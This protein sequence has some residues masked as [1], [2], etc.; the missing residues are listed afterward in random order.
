MHTILVVDDEDRI[1][2]I[3]K[4]LFER[5]GFKVIDASNIVDARKYLKTVQIDL[6]L[7]DINMGEL[8][9]DILYEVARCFHQ[10]IKIIVSSVYPVEDQRKLMPDALDYFDKSEGNR[11][12]VQKVE[13]AL[14]NQ[15]KLKKKKVILIIDDDPKQKELFRNMLTEAGYNSIELSDDKE[16]ICFL[17]KQ[18]NKIDLIVLDLAMPSKTGI[19]YF[20]DIKE[21]YQKTKVLIAS[22]Y[23]IEE[24][25]T[26][27]FDAD[28][29]FDKS[30]GN[31]VFLKKVAQLV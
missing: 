30:D 31:A 13:R 2:S 21:K 9:G 15:E 5:K 11:T 25:K 1:R 24:Q 20:D 27:V 17:K 14:V 6:I 23:S 4:S 7:L 12:L 3:Y 16:V 28:D 22:N 18:V 8:D 26:C 29:Y 19:D 10:N